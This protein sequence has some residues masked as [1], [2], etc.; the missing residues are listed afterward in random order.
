MDEHGCVD[1]AT[2]CFVVDPLYTL[3]I[4]D[5][6]S[7]NGDGINDVF[8]PKGTYIKD[9]EMYIF[10][11]WGQK[12]FHSTNIFNGWNGTVNGGSSIAQEDTYVYQVIVNTWDGNQT[13]VI[14]RVTVLR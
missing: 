8:M 1:S 10:D 12:L 4:P 3:Y 11:R 9:F 2:N 6:F 5:A 13:T 14:G 7:P